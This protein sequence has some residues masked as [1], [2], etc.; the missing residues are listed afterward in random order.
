MSQLG[1]DVNWDANEPST[2][3]S[4]NKDVNSFIFFYTSILI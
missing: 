1:F 2:W 3:G 4:S